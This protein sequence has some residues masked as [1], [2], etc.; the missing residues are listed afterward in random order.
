MATHASVLTVEDVPN[1][2][3]QPPASYK[4]PKRTFGK[5]VSFF[6]ASLVQS[7]AICFT[8]VKRMTLHTMSTCLQAE[9]ENTDPALVSCMYKL[10]QH[11][12]VCDRCNYIDKHQEA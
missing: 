2:P 4:F 10:H 9:E 7:M 3:H 11:N 8:T 5:N 12:I 1:K 6:P